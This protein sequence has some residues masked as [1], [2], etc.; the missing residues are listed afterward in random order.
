MAKRN[1]AKNAAKNAAKSARIQ[2]RHR[3]PLEREREKRQHA[4]RGAYAE[5]H[6]DRAA[7][8][9]ALRKEHA[10]AE[11]DFGHKRHGTVE[12]LQKA[13]RTR[14]GAIARMYEAGHLSIDQL[15]AAVSIR[16]VFTRIGSDV[17]P[18]TASWE[19]RVDV[20]RHGSGFFEALS[21]VRAEVAYGRWRNDL[22]RPAI[23]LAMICEDQGYTVAAR[24]FGM[25]PENARALLIDA[26][27]LWPEYV[28]RACEE[29]DEAELMAAQAGI[30]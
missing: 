5:R 2:K 28:G 4:I 13:S 17:C 20:S 24:Q 21:A 30:L 23:V 9:R 14:Q 3:T 27:D 6:P 15:A 22:P 25:R 7:Q 29:I 8:E 1:T 18:S 10:A 16:D 12:T 19:T 11:R 26:L